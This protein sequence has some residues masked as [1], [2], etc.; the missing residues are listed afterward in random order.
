MQHLKAGA[1]VTDTTEIMN[2]EQGIITIDNITINAPTNNFKYGIVNNSSN[3]IT[4]NNATITAYTNSVRNAG[5]G[6][7]EINGGTFNNR[8]TNVLDGKIKITGGTFNADVENANKSTG[9]IEITGGTLKNVINQ[10]SGTPTIKVS[11]TTL[12]PV[13]T[14]ITNNKDGTLI[15]TGG[16][17]RNTSG[18]GI[19]N[20][21]YLTIG[22]KDNS[23]DTT[24][25]SI[26]G[27][28]YGVYHTGQEF[29]FYDGIIE[30]ATGKT[31]YG[32]ID[33]KE[34]EFE[35]M[36]YKPGDSPNF[37]VNTGREVKVLVQ[38]NIVEVLST[39][40]TYISLQEAVNAV[41][42]GATG[43]TLV[44]LKNITIMANSSPVTIPN[45]KKIILDLNDKTITASNENTFVN[46]GQFEVIDSSENK[47]GK[48]VNT[49]STIIKSNSGSVL[50]LTSGTLRMDAKGEINNYI[51]VIKSEGTTVLQGINIIAQNVYV[52]ALHLE[53][54]G[55]VAISEGEVK[56]NTNRYF[57][58]VLND[59]TGNI[60][61]TATE[62]ADV[63]L[64][65]KDTQSI[66]NNSS[67][68]ILINNGTLNNITNNG[69]GTITINDGKIGEIYN[70][71]AGDITIYNG[72][73]TSITNT[74]NATVIIEDG[75][76]TSSYSAIYN[77]AG[78]IVKVKGGTIKG[79]SS[80]AINVDNK[81]TGRIEISGGTII[82]GVS[83]NGTSTLEVSGNPEIRGSSGSSRGIYNNTNA[84][85]VITGG[86]IT[87]TS[88]D[89]TSTS[90][91]IYN[92]GTLTLG[93]MDSELK[94]VPVI[95]GRPY[96]VYN[97]GTFNFYDGIINGTNKYA[98]YGKVS[99]IQGGTTIEITKSD[100][101]ETAKLVNVDYIAQVGQT[102]Y[103]NLKDA[104]TACGNNGEITIL[105]DFSMVTDDE[106]EIAS[107]NNVTINLNGKTITGF[108]EDSLITNNG[109]LTIKD[110]SSLHAGK[111]ESRTNDVITNVGT[112]N[113]NSGNIYQ[114]FA[115][116][117]AVNNTGGTLNLNGAT[118]SSDLERKAYG[119]KNS[120]SGSVTVS[121]GTI[122]NFKYRN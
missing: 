65:G 55:S 115:E 67:G 92:T 28:D 113:I 56:S 72:T 75:T 59:G 118:I 110:D 47:T 10:T 97:T 41:S 54:S 11:G 4:I 8:I 73:I 35:I 49:E 17:I 106:V 88:T 96:G 74:E 94:E 27:G 22:T 50:T 121:S 42:A 60:Q 122:S 119:I 58:S 51:D 114:N 108:A 82:G 30:G 14:K 7:I 79:G 87:G 33:D 9:E 53:G 80:L 78:G 86:T 116:K 21:G 99:E 61:I 12:S 111:I 120:S 2:N 109:I 31:T 16:K 84:T 20:K 32:T 69:T 24:N 46:N 38:E 18:Y 112:L 6:T 45:D 39:G 43:D 19:D 70:H 89:D 95:S 91:G 3:K 117:Y 105:N 102:Q 26:Y 37:T 76:I 101:I 15:V 103:N 66:L 13:I 23:S 104:V 1:L 100:N 64:Q 40:N 34:T 29:N 57:R 93:T 77:K 98:I 36:S 25:P 85:A 44:M 107:G 90:A 71:G 83:N 68:N 81:S 63:T 62:L 52:C 5:S 48:I